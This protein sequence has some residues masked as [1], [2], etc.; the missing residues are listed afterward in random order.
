M[1]ICAFGVGGRM[2]I[3]KRRLSEDS[4]EGRYRRLVLLPIPTTKDKK[5]ITGTNTEL[6]ALLPL[7]GPGVLFV[8]YAIPDGIGDALGVC[9]SEIYDLSLNEGFLAENAILTAHGVVGRLLLSTQESVIGL[10]VGVI[11]YGRIGKEL[12]RILL[13]LGARVS[14]LTTSKSTLEELVYSG[15]DARLIGDAPNIGELDMLINTAPSRLLDKV[16]QN[17]LLRIP[18][19][20]ELA[21]GDNLPSLENI[22]RHP[23]VPEA[24]YPIAAGEIFAKY[25]NKILQN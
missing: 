17:D 16:P 7:G 11:G 5:F 1:E 22:E 2:E 6:E 10:R 12:V 13:F 9:G 14:V 4:R 8:G 15:V 19:I 23:S 20:L 3:C 18:R 24:C 21:S 25:V